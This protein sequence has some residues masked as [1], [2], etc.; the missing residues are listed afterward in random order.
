MFQRADR[1]SPSRGRKCFRPEIESC[2]RREV[3]STLTLASATVLPDGRTLQLVFN[4]PLPGPSGAPDWMPGY[5][6]GVRLATGAGDTLEN[7]GNYVTSHA[8]TL[9]WTATY[10]IDD[11]SNAVLFNQTGVSLGAGA[12]LLQD[13]NGDSTASFTSFPVANRSLIDAGGFTTQSFT[14]G[15]GGVTLYVSSTHGDDTRTFAQAEN[16]ATPY[17]T[18]AQALNQAFDNGMNGKGADVRLLRGDTFSAGGKIK[19]SGQDP[20]HPL[21]IEDYWYNYGDGTTD[22]GTRPILA[23]DE[24]NSRATDVLDTTGGGGTAATVNFVV[25]R[26]LA[27]EAVNWTG[28]IANRQGLN[29]LRGGTDWTLD[30]CLIQNFGQNVIFQGFDGPFENVTLLRCVIEDARIDNSVV[31]G[32]PQGLYLSNVH[33]IDISQC[34]FDDNGRVSADR[35]GRDI[36][37]HNVYIQNDCG[38]AVVWGNVFHSGGSHG[39]QMR[40]G[41][42]LAYNY[43]GRNAIAAFVDAPGGSQYKNVV[44]HAEDISPSLPR[45]FGLSANSAYGSS[46]AQAIEFNIL[47]NFS[48]HQNRAISLDQ[49]GLNGISHVIVRH[50][51]MVG[52]GLFKFNADINIPSYV[53][54]GIANN[55]LDA[56]SNPLY[57]APA[58]TSWGWYQADR[59]ALNT[60]VPSNQVTQLG[61][62]VLTL[63]G[64]SAA[65][66]GSEANSVTVPP[67][68][69]NDTADIG[70]FYASVGGPG[71]EDAYIALLRAR[72]PGI[73]GT[74]Y[75]TTAVYSY[76]AAAYQPTNLPATGPGPF[77]YYGAADYRTP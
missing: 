65:T 26:R 44:E 3:L 11:P 29:F 76:F 56:R 20:Q 67:H 74:P 28:N 19:I 45:G 8:D 57:V 63:S 48:G 16:P 35:S 64:W 50:N 34:T 31:S 38:P 14:R 70:G 58:F 66:N 37:S 39:I 4:A 21:V 60:T 61:V 25:I 17:R 6:A 51:T 46:V 9:S 42:V 1:R 13:G 12:G 22:P 32:H 40:S 71:S 49:V 69:V 23:E 30:D 68:Y 10:L 53:S 75:D 47:V 43:F 2:E 55:I 15:T 33:G 77:D 36:F 62:P 72:S 59:N 27:I 41:G 73:W 18:L 52:A 54:V 7:I 5:T 24:T